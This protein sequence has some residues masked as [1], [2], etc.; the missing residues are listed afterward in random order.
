MSDEKAFDISMF[1]DQFESAQ[2]LLDKYIELK[3][4]ILQVFFSVNIFDV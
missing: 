3:S 2:E 1:P 4:Y